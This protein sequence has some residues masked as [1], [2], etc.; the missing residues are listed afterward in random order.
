MSSYHTLLLERGHELRELK[1]LLDDVLDAREAAQIRAEAAE[2]ERD[3]LRTELV[4]MR[5]A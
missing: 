2:R 4:R 5:A 1:R 3:A